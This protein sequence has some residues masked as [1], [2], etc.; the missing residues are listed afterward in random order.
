M[1]IVPLGSRGPILNL[2]WFLN[3][4]DIKLVRPA[5]ELEIIIVFK[6]Q[7][8]RLFQLLSRLKI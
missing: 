6:F 4:P 3:N 5:S 1:R 7:T 8:L 2:L